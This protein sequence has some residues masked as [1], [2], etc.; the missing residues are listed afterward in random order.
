[1]SLAEQLHVWPGSRGG[2]SRDDRSTRELV[3]AGVWR[4]LKLELWRQRPIPRVTRDS[5]IAL[6]MRT[7]SFLNCLVRMAYKKGLQHELRGSTNT[8]NTL[9]C[10][11]E[12][13]CS[14]KT[15]VREKNAIGDQQIKS[16]KTSRAIRFAIRESF[17]FH[18]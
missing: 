6:Q 1:M 5:S 4:L 17:E 3:L 12:I 14:P 11:R 10:S 8:V 2:S 16:V 18:A 7:Q 15:A 9:A 13:R